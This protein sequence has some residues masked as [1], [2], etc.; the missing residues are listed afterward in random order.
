MLAE[1]WP[2]SRSGTLRGAQ[3]HIEDDCDLAS[4]TLE[5]D[6]DLAEM[7]IVEDLNL[8]SEGT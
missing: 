3:M 2:G 1:G 8:S 5:H 6:R 4:L 7:Q